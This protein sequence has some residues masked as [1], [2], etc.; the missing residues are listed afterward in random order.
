M[1]TFFTIEPKEV[2]AWPIRIGLTADKAAG[3]IHS[4]F[5]KGFIKAETISFIDYIKYGSKASCKNAGRIRFE[6]RDYIVQ[7]GDIIHFKFNI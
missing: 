4:D 6:G 7:D 5:K 2:R 1:I 3:I